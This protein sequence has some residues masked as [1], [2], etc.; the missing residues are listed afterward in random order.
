MQT[1]VILFDI[2]ETVLDL[3]PLRPKFNQFFGHHHH[4]DTWFAML[5][6]SSTVCIA[7]GVKTD[8]KSL[9]QAA[10]YNLAGRLNITLSHGDCHTLLNTFAQLPAHQ[11][12]EP[13]LK[14]LKQAGYKLVAFSNSSH[15][16]LDAQ[17]AHARIV[18]LFDDVISVEAAGTFKPAKAA[19]QLAITTLECP[20]DKLRLVATHDW[21]T[22]GALSAGLKAAHINRLNSPYH[23]HYK[24][25]DVMANNMQQLVHDIIERDAS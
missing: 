23:S 15:A 19:Y 1:Q 4:M 7:T 8:F 20:A 12:I 25:P 21:D 11:D 18:D 17:L 5:L 16:L 24:Q 13:A 10:L 2:N 22:H 9:A 14:H 6:H 3:S